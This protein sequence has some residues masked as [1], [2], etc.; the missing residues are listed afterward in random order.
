VRGGII[1]EDDADLIGEIVRRVCLCGGTG[2]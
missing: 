1:L 2:K